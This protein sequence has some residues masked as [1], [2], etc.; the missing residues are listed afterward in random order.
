MANWRRNRLLA[1]LV[2][3]YKGESE[4]GQADA[5]LR[6]KALSCLNV[7]RKRGVLR[8]TSW[9]SVRRVEVLFPRGHVFPASISQMLKSL[10]SVVPSSI[11]QCAHQVVAR[12]TYPKQQGAVATIQ[13]REQT[14]VHQIVLWLGGQ[15]NPNRKHVR[16]WWVESHWMATMMEM[17]PYKEQ[18]PDCGGL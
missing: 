18:C 13:G 12:C 8:A 14:D 6:Y 17:L 9:S 10:W 5:M 1:E 4:V 15:R 7:Q 2:G 16:W 11:I 3:G